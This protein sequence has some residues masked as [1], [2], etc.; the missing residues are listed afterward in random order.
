[1]AWL[2]ERVVFGV[3]LFAAL[4]LVLNLIQAQNGTL[5]PIVAV[6]TIPGQR[7]RSPRHA[8][9]PVVLGSN[10]TVQ[11]ERT[12]IRVA[13]S[14]PQLLQAPRGEPSR[15]RVREVYVPQ[16]PTAAAQPLRAQPRIRLRTPER[17]R[18]PGDATAPGRLAPAWLNLTSALRGRGA[19]QLNESWRCPSG[20]QLELL[21]MSHNRQGKPFV[22]S[23]KTTVPPVNDIVAL[24]PPPTCMLFAFF[25]FDKAGGTVLREYFD[26][27]AAG[28]RSRSAV[29]F[30]GAPFF[31]RLPEYNYTWWVDD[32]AARAQLP[33]VWI[34]FHAGRFG[35]TLGKLSAIRA[36]LRNTGCQVLSATMIR[37]PVAQLQ[38]AFMYW[39]IQQKHYNGTIFQWS[40][41]LGLLPQEAGGLGPGRT[42]WFFGRVKFANTTHRKVWVGGKQQ[43]HSVDLNPCNQRVGKPCDPRC[44]EMLHGFLRAQDVVAPTEEWETVFLELSARMGLTKMPLHYKPS[45]CRSLLMKREAAKRDSLRH[46]LVHHRD[47]LRAYVPCSLEVYHHWA[48]KYRQRVATQ[49]WAS[50][51]FRAR[52]CTLEAQYTC[53]LNHGKL[54]KYEAKQFTQFYCRMQASIAA[55]GVCPEAAAGSAAGDRASGRRDDGAAIGKQKNEPGTAARAARSGRPLALR[56]PPQTVRAAI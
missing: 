28:C 22:E 34:E 14:A 29:D 37:E 47:E 50:D 45:Q 49:L 21:G 17:R 27:L 5:D 23:K 20:G 48:E 6:P 15:V 16:T 42:D 51:A 44:R 55:P 11:A 13:P 54:S 25:H 8:P 53:H 3:T 30:C 2:L 39:G 24:P 19:P 26:R 18:V 32:A 56:G 9:P 35:L 43:R 33:R 4:L 46:G 52:V 36:A 1:M 10:R 31:E 12:Q 7:E 40:D 41:E 38:S